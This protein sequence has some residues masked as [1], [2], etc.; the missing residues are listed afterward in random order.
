MV[1]YF[2]NKSFIYI[3]IA[4]DIFLFNKVGIAHHFIIDCYAEIIFQSIIPDISGAKVSTAEKS[5]FQA[6]QYEILSVKLDTIYANKAILCFESKTSLSFIGTVRVDT[7]VGITNF[8]II[9]TSILFFLYLK[10]MDILKVYLNN[11]IN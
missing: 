2:F 4:Q 8:Y 5:Q 6:L 10:N 3:F 7:L 1:A 9:D 11:I